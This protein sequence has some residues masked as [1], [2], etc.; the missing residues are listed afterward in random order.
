MAPDGKWETALAKLGL[1]AKRKVSDPIPQ[2]DVFS[3][4]ASQLCV[5]NHHSR[6]LHVD[7]HHRSPTASHPDNHRTPTSSSSLSGSWMPM[8]P[9]TPQ[10]FESISA[11]SMDPVE[12]ATN[13]AQARVA[14]FLSDDDDRV[15]THK[16]LSKQCLNA[17]LQA[18]MTMMD[19]VV[20]QV[21]P[22]NIVESKLRLQ[23]IKDGFFKYA[24]SI[25]HE[26]DLLEQCVANGTKPLNE[27]LPITYPAKIFDRPKKR[28]SGM[29]MDEQ[30]E[31]LPP[32]SQGDDDT[33]RPTLPQ[34]YSGKYR[35]DQQSDDPYAGMEPKVMK[36]QISG[37]FKNDTNA[38]PF[39][40]SDISIRTISSTCTKESKVLKQQQ[41]GY[42]EKKS[43]A[44]QQQT[45]DHSLPRSPSNP[46]IKSETLK[47][48]PS[49]KEISRFS[50]SSTYS[51]KESDDLEKQ[52]S[53][54][55]MQDNDSK[56]PPVGPSNYAAIGLKKDPCEDFDPDF[57]K[58]LN[59]SAFI[60]A[61]R[62]LPLHGPSLD[63]TADNFAPSLQ[64]SGARTHTVSSDEWIMIQS[65]TSPLSPTKIVAHGLDRID[66]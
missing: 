19:D 27:D 7:P 54:S 36:K 11:A 66:E 31:L 59:F 1:K 55:D 58:A 51:F 38:L 9:L 24:D 22:E 10:S 42:F 49:R 63:Q 44:L 34:R 8:T 47:S 20:A 37:Y 32:P 29:F 6:N 57:I 39:K 50:G 2:G 64:G 5:K 13:L 28:P 61:N 35:S 23:D 16:I 60:P 53:D 65:T 14:A 45:A 56:K 12:M 52:L 26:A 25:G 3:V 43:V 33:P 4:H 41:S 17:H 46:D 21:T 40:T 30:A 62:A 48:Q 18:S 15:A